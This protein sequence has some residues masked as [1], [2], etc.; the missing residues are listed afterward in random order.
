MRLHDGRPAWSNEPCANCVSEVKLTLGTFSARSISLHP[1]VR[2][3]H[4]IRS[5]SFFPAWSALHYIH[6]VST[7]CHYAVANVRA[8]FN[9]VTV[10]LS[11]KKSNWSD[12]KRAFPWAQTSQNG[13]VL[14]FLKLNAWN[15][16]KNRT[17]SESGKQRRQACKLVDSVNV[18]L[19]P[20]GHS[21][22]LLYRGIF[23]VPAWEKRWNLGSL[24]PKQPS[25]TT[26]FCDED[27]TFKPFKG[28]LEYIYLC[29]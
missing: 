1:Q 19:F 10:N 4:S 28:I 26:C 22:S 20:R 7:S 3:S 29:I 23:Q 9:D 6:L 15:L 18:V 2:Y 8:R 12:S 5:S 25:L 11:C 13:W 16:E 27:P 24:V 17:S 21:F 14:Q